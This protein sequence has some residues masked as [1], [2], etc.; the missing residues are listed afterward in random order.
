MRRYGSD[1]LRI[2]EDLKCPPPGTMQF[3]IGDF[4][5]GAGDR[6]PTA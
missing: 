3:T 2:R 1:Q 6:R 4:S 5:G